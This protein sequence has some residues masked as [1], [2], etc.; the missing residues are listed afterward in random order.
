MELAR[1]PGTSQSPPPARPRAR[2]P[3]SRM[4]TVPSRDAIRRRKLPAASSPR[5]TSPMP[6]ASEGH[7]PDDDASACRH[8]FGGPIR[9]PNS[10]PASTDGEWSRGP[11][12]AGWLKSRAVDCQHGADQTPT[13]VIG[14]A[15]DRRWMRRLVGY[16]VLDHGSR[17]LGLIKKL[18][19]R[20]AAL[21]GS[22][23]GRGLVKKAIPARSSRGLTGARRSAPRRRTR[24]ASSAR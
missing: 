14:K 7:D 8:P 19:E 6:D 20:G 22:S 12:L 16:R 9:R 24:I 15:V 17:R 13:Q 4:K 5:S 21:F 1:C 10:R 2:G 23:V 3:S 18:A 11:T